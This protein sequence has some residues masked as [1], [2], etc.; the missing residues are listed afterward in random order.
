MPFEA[1]Q[2]GFKAF[3]RD[4][5]GYIDA[6]DLTEHISNFV[7]ERDERDDNEGE[8][9]ERSRGRIGARQ[10]SFQETRKSSSKDRSRNISRE[11]K[12]SSSPDWSKYEH[13][14]E[15]LI[16]RRDLDRDGRINMQ[17]FVDAASEEQ[18][19]EEYQEKV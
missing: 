13:E 4:G 8:E 1:L 5:D 17:E 11:S 9:S 15:E 19:M 6:H 16:A 14:A 3:D 12:R 2:E 7:R 10:G 18:E